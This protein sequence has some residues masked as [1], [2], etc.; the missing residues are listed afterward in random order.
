MLRKLHIRNFAIIDD[1]ELVFTPGLNI[2]SGETGAGKSIILDSLGLLMGHKALPSWIRTGAQEAWVEATCDLP[3]PAATTAT[4]VVLHRTIRASGRSM[5]RINGEICARAALQAV[6]QTLIEIHGQSD[7]LRLLDTSSHLQ[8]LDRFAHLQTDR[9]ALAHKVQDLQRVRQQLHQARTDTQTLMQRT[10]MLR[11][12]V[13]EIR[14]ADI[15]P[16]EEDTL[17][18]EQTR[19]GNAEKLGELASA[20]KI[21]LEEGGAEIP[22]ILDLLGETQSSL[23]QLAQI[24]SSQAT[25]ADTLQQAI[26]LIYDTCH[27]M[28]DYLESLEQDPRQLQQVEERLTL[29]T[30]LQKKYGPTLEDV[31]AVRHQGGRRTARS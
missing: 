12:Q 17:R 16:G 24:D 19:L 21:R 1:L 2:L 27:A 9:E 10:D 3:E 30:T 23:L 31:V 15:Q 5:C 13:A 4:T 25:Q 14:E 18:Q 11:F 6:M 28:E 26:D 20:C 8:L 22:S 7:H 29:L